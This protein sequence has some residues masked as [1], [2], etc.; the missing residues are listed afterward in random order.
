MSTRECAAFTIGAR[1]VYVLAGSRGAVV[2]VRS[3]SDDNC[4]P[5]TVLVQLD[6]VSGESPPHMWFRPNELA[7]EATPTRA[8]AFASAA[9]RASEVTEHING[10]GTIAAAGAE[11]TIARA[12]GLQ[13][14]LVAGVSPI[15]ATPQHVVDSRSYLC[16]R[17]ANPVRL[18]AECTCTERADALA[19]TCGTLTTQ[20]TELLAENARLRRELER[21]KPKPKP[22]EKRTEWQPTLATGLIPRRG[23]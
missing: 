21:G 10:T 7:P 12:L 8:A 5:R 20:N 17:C 22:A 23:R 9:A 4:N 14:A 13:P 6:G 2:A 16:S 19:D 15:E 1:V 11:L 3:E 18:G